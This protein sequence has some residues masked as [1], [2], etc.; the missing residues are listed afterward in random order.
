MEAGVFVLFVFGL[1]RTLRGFVEV[2][3]DTYL[4]GRS[5]LFIP[6]FFS[7]VYLTFCFIIEFVGGT[8]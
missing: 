6:V 1:L 5:L 4:E 3:C 7:M 8:V 2:I